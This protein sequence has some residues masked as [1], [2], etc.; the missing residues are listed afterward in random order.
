MKKNKLGIRIEID[1]DRPYD[2]GHTISLHSNANIQYRT[3]VFCDGVNE[4]MD[5]GIFIKKHLK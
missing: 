2:L 3:R 5:F 1:V 4:P